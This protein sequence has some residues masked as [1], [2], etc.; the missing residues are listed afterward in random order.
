MSSRVTTFSYE[1]RHLVTEN[2]DKVI[3]EQQQQPVDYTSLAAL[4]VK[5]LGIRSCNCNFRQTAAKFQQ[6][7]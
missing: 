7:S 3:S 5:K 1:S 4:W 2:D 6:Q